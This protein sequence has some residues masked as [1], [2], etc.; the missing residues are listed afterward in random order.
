MLATS[1]EGWDDEVNSGGGNGGGNGASGAPANEIWYTTGSAL[2]LAPTKVGPDVFGAN[3]IS[4]TYEKG[5]GVLRFDAPVTK[6]GEEA[7][8]HSEYLTT[9]T[10]PKG[11]TEIG[12]D[13]FYECSSLTA[14]YISSIEA[15]CKISFNNPSSNPLCYA[16]K[17]YL[18]GELVTDLVI[19]DG[20]TKIGSY[21]FYNYTN[22]T[23]ITIPDSVTSIGGS[24]F[25]FCDN[26]TS[27]T[28]PDSVTS[29]GRSAFSNCSSLKSITIP[30][31]VTTIGAGA[32]V[33]CTGEAIIKSC[34][35]IEK[36]YKDYSYTS[37]FWECQFSKITLPESLTKIGNYVFYGST[38]LT[39]ISIPDSVTSIGTYA[40][41][42]CGSLKEVYCKPTI[43]PTLG[44]CVFDS[45]ASG[46][47]IYVPTNSVSAY[48]S[49]GGWSQYASAIV[50][51]NF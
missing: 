9:I 33:G 14:V 31:S 46:R 20:V 12:D 42:G 25:A 17:L 26:L 23:S 15:W 39:Q 10:L 4:N 8:S 5:R 41:C 43:P 27:V 40:F 24:A 30:D 28:I 35:V 45:N 18:N 6:I 50:G 34:T 7:F 47:K 49:A 29:I 13:A 51:Y 36:D 22:L 19:P 21:A 37:P 11:I 16:E 2:P 1:C 38:G 3:I 48:K 32:F 44:Y